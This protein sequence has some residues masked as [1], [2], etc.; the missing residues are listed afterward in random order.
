MNL[1]IDTDTAG[2]DVFSL[3]LALRTP[4]V[5]LVGISIN[6]GNVAFEQ[7]VENAL[8]TVEV[9]GRSG[10]VPVY[11]GC[12]TPMIEPWVSATYVHGEDGMGDSYFPRAKQRPASEHAVDALIQCLS[13]APGEVTVVAQAPLTNLAVAYL[14]KPFLAKLLIDAI[15]SVS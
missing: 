14:R 4:G 2:D 8:Y 11:R 3:L 12:D 6:V 5:D 15:N 7:E 13:Q 10:E 1:W 9:A